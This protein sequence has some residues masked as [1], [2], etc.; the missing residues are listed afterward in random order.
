[1]PKIIIRTKPQQINVVEER[2]VR[3]PFYNAEDEHTIQ[4]S[5]PGNA[6]MTF[7]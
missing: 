2:K 5:N 4:E 6:R 1:V 7:D 3:D